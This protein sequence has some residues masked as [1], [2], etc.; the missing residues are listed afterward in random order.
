[1]R[2][3]LLIAALLL[4]F[5]LVYILCR[6]MR[7]ALFPKTYCGLTEEEWAKRGKKVKF[8]K[9]GKANVKDDH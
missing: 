4:I 2:L 1:M 8:D 5:V 6:L 7:D 3:I 9:N